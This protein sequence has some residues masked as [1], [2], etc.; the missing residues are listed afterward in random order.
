[1]NR[2]FFNLPPEEQKA[3]IRIAEDKHG[4][5][6]NIIEKDLWLCWVLEQLFDLP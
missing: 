3:I 5:P 1:M 2:S 4:L 6:S